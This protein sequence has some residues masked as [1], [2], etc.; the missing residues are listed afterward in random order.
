MWEQAD[1]TPYTGWPYDVPTE[2][3][4][5]REAQ[6]RRAERDAAIMEEQREIQAV[7]DLEALRGLLVVHCDNG[8]IAAGSVTVDELLHA[9]DMTIGVRKR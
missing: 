6:E 9:I 4:L 2:D 1:N 7:D 8:F 5:A 3:Q